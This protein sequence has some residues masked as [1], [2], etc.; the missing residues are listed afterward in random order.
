MSVETYFSK[1][2]GRLALEIF[3][4][5]TVKSIYQDFWSTIFINNLE[6]IMTE[7]I[8]EKINANKSAGNKKVKINKI[9]KYIRNT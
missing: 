2:K 5:K 6:T 9:D 3:T 7:D 1:V 4:G 8:E